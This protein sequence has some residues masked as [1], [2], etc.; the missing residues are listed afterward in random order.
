MSAALIARAPPTEPGAAKMSCAPHCGLSA[1]SSIGVQVKSSARSIGAPPSSRAPDASV[2]QK[3]SIGS[4]YAVATNPITSA[5]TAIR[6]RIGS[7]GERTVD[8]RPSVD[9]A[10]TRAS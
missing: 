6:A 8:G 3:S 9:L 7:R 5:T 1:P 10:V 4:E 2:S